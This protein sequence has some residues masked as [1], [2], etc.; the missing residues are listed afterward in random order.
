MRALGELIDSTDALIEQIATI[1][2]TGKAT[3]Q[4][5]TTTADSD[6]YVSTNADQNTG[7]GN[8]DGGGI[9]ALV[10]GRIE[11]ENHYFHSR[12]SGTA[13]NAPHHI[14][15]DLGDGNSINTFKFSYVAHNAP[16]PTTIVVSG[17]NDGADFT[18]IE[19]IT[20]D[21]IAVSSTYTSK[22]FESATAYRYLRFEVTASLRD[23]FGNSFGNYVCFGMKE[24]DLYK[25]TSSAEVAPLYKNLA[26]VTNEE[27]ATVYDSLAEA[28][29]VYNNGGTA[30]E[31]QA[32][33]NVLKPLYD[34]LKAKKDKIFNGVYNINYN[35][36]P[37]FIAYAAANELS[38]LTGAG[39]AGF[40]LF[41][42]T[43]TN[44]DSK[45]STIQNNAIAAQAAADALFTIVPKEDN[46]GY[47]LQAQGWYMRAT[48]VHSQ[49]DIQ[50]FDT[51][52]ANAGTYLFEETATAGVF[53]L[54]STIN[55]HKNSAVTNYVNDWG[56]VFGCDNS[57][58]ENLSTFTLTQVTE[59]TLSVPE[60]GVTTL[61]LP[62]NV[63]L[64]AGVTAY[65]ITEANITGMGGADVYALSAVA[66]EGETLAKNTP[67]IVK[68]TA[69]DYVL[70]ITMSD[71]DAKASNEGSVL[72][73]GLVK[74]TVAANYTFDGENFNLVTTATEVPANQC[75]MQVSDKGDVIYNS[76]VVP[77]LTVDEENPVL[78]KIEIKRA[79]D[80]SKVLLY[81]EPND[82]KVR[83]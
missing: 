69:G 72:R 27:T 56:P 5:L 26:G 66:A 33:Y 8:A 54:K 75:Y 24:L 65:D 48:G 1:N 4:P 13:V 7:G 37:L 77:I 59:Y 64:P 14:Q 74:T 20:K 6:F 40:R 44:T 36:V 70:T 78:Y 55:V 76:A 61:C 50:A 34:D 11:G 80:G 62:F 79:N 32:A 42:A 15:I 30:D 49:W 53:K 71:E 29:Y 51:D 38:G 21:V 46:S 52:V 43:T 63:V 67:V 22:V 41:D 39:N 2:P 28:L 16:D 19:T 60:S 68:A 3:A 83:L 18:P 31:M 9:A 23:G 12:W 47:L 58:K 45:H 35:D 81:D 57:N 82:E 10:D 73:S 17:S 25:V